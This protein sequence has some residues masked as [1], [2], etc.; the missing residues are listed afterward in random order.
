[1]EKR[2]DLR[3]DEFS[4]EYYCGPVHICGDGLADAFKSQLDPDDLS[5]EITLVISEQEHPNAREFKFFDT[6]YGGGSVRFANHGDYSY[7]IHNSFRRWLVTHF[8][9]GHPLWM[10]VEERR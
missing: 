9:P 5:E 8:K 7:A 3:L 4:E 10:R 1:M 2:L 6:M